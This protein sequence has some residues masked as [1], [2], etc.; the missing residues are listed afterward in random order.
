MTTTNDGPAEIKTITESKDGESSLPPN[1]Q[2]VAQDTLSQLSVPDSTC[3]WIMDFLFDWTQH[4][5]LGNDSRCIST[6]SPQGCILSPLLLSLY[7][8]GCAYSHQS[9]TLLKIADDTTLIRL[10]SGGDESAYRWEIDR[11][12]TWCSQN[13]LELNALKTEEIV[14]GFGKNAAPPVPITLCN[15]QVDI[16]ESLCFP[17]TVITQDLKWELNIN[18]ITKKG[19][20]R[21]YLHRLVMQQ[22][23]KFNL[24]KTMMVHLYTFITESILT[25][26]ITK[27]LRHNNIFFPSAAGVINMAKGSKNVG[28]FLKTPALKTEIAELGVYE[29]KGEKVKQTLKRDGFLDTKLRKNC[30]LSQRGTEVITEMSNLVDDLDGKS[31]PIILLNRSSPPE[32]QP[33]SL[34]D[35]YITQSDSQGHDPDE[36]QDTLQQSTTTDLENNNIPGEKSK[37]HGVADPENELREIPHSKNLRT[38]VPKLYLIQNP[39]HV[40]YGLNDQTCREAKMMKKQMEFSDSVCHRIKDKDIYGDTRRQRYEKVTNQF[41]IP[42]YPRRVIKRK[43]LSQKYVKPPDKEKKRFRGCDSSC[44][45]GPSSKLVNSHVLA[46]GSKNVLKIMKNPALNT[47]IQKVSIYARTQKKVR[48]ALR[49][50]GPFFNTKFRKNYDLHV[51]NRKNIRT[52]REVKTMKKL[53]GLS[54]SVCLP[55]V[56]GRPGVRGFLFGKFD[57]KK[58]HVI[59]RIYKDDGRQPNE[60][61]TA[62]FRV[63]H[64]PCSLIKRKCLSQKYVKLL[65]KETKRFR[66]YVSY[67]KKKTSCK[68][69]IFHV[70]TKGGENVVEIMKSPALNTEIK[71]VTFN[72]Y[73]RKKL[74][75]ALRRHGPFFITQFGKNYVLLV[76]YRKNDHTHTKVKTMKKLMELSDSVCQV[77]INGRP[78]GSGFMLFG[79]FV[80]TN[81]HVIYDNDKRQLLEGVTV[82]FS[83]ESLE[84]TEGRVV[85]VEEVVGFEYRPG[86]S[87]Y[88]WALLRLSANNLPRGLLANFGFLPQSGSVYI[89]GHPEGG[90]KKLSHCPIV[91]IENR[92]KHVESHKTQNQHNQSVTPKFFEDVAACVQNKQVLTYESCFYYGSSGSPV[93][94]K[95]CN[96]VAVH[97]GGYPYLSPRGKNSVIECGYPLSGIM[98]RMI[99][100]MMERGRFDVL[101]E[102]EVES[103]NLTTFKNSH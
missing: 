5:K 80:L 90:V 86:V 44:K 33:D 73:K 95:D 54:D 58:K 45:K 98:E 13:S 42:H 64:Y 101:E 24:T 94:D 55:R 76:E 65:D 6:S 47:E 59:K 68:P 92:I 49:R 67:C 71:K 93:F 27:T 36:S 40:E 56:N 12:V 81:A 46:K 19:Q 72:A 31:F 66:G 41:R 102:L 25:S 69:G 23:R 61:V 30:A 37:H 29:Y 88:D 17:G 89:I 70:L 75:E 7:T 28:K 43:H 83:F 62:H 35:A 4:M 34:D 14:V 52:C 79:K 53:M 103:K 18:S 77:R 39:L 96:V 1:L 82:D 97:S 100:Q 85:T 9:V 22:L 87:P 84:Q 99:I 60:R 8:N 2:L 10:I 57:L 78:A 91:P 50:D 20:Q 21:M 63:L 74:L 48:R 3:S 16:V 11:L 38:Q 32:N 26:S 15:S 51:E